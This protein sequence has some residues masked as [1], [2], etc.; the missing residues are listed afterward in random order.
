MRSEGKLAVAYARVSSAEQEQSGYSIAA[1][2]KLVTD[3]ARTHGFTIVEWFVEARS[4][5]LGA[6]R[7]EFRRMC[8][9]LAK[10]RTVRVALCERV[11][12]AAP[13]ARDRPRDRAQ[14]PSQPSA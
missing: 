11:D 8:S 7:K 9:Y 6:D 14:L 5:K 2:R 12:D 10:H 1:Q 4:G 13:A 3:Y